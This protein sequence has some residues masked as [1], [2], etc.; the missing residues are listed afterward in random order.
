MSSHFTTPQQREKLD[1]LR[2]RLRDM[3]AVAVSFSG[4]V[5]S[6][7]LLAVAHEQLGERALA[8]TET[9]ALYPERET[10]GAVAFCAERGIT[11]VLLRHDPESVE[12]FASNPRNRCYLCKRDLFGHLQKAADEKAVELGMIKPG[13]HIPCAEGSNVTDLADYRP[14]A[15]AVKERGV[16]SPLQEVGLTKQDIRDLSRQLELPTWDKPSFACL[17]SRFVYGETISN[18]LLERVD[19]A[20]QLLIDAGFSQVRVRVHDG[21]ATARVEV[22]GQRIADALAFLREGG[23]TRLHELGFSHVSL[24]VDGYRTGSMNE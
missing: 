14:G 16:S 12:G 19:Q 7:L 13:E 10:N 15:Q 8:V 2:G 17:A 11:Q 1:A 24:D 21:G 22:E 20:E 9:S 5:D 3:G 4:G 18:P 23:S 6:T